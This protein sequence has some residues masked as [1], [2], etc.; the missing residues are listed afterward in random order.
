MGI[1]VAPTDDGG[2]KMDK[3]RGVNVHAVE[4]DAARTRAQVWELESPEENRAD[5]GEKS[6]EWE[7][8]PAE[9]YRDRRRI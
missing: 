8:Y 4:L 7:R 2:P 9:K 5:R 3:K 6:E 1:W